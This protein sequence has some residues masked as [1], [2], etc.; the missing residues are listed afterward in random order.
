MKLTLRLQAIE[1]FLP[2][3]I[4]ADIG[5]DHA[6]LA[7]DAVIKRKVSKAY[8]CDV[9]E[10]PYQ[11]A[12]HTI[13]ENNL[14]GKVIPVLSNGLDKVPSDANICVVAGMGVETMKMILS[15]DKIKQ[16]HTLILQPNSDADELRR[17]AYSNQLNLVDESIVCEG[18]YYFILKYQNEPAEPLSE[19]E[20]LFGKFCTHKPD[21]ADYWN[22]RKQRL[23][24]IVSQMQ[25]CPKKKELADFLEQINKQLAAL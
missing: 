6:Y 7:C 20:L 4:L 19:N 10:G 24:N 9:K 16:F 15:T 14:E 21:Y 18:H 12:C 1:D 13:R 23:E 25:E 8:A 2:E 5:C 17:W 3:G 11:A 22:F